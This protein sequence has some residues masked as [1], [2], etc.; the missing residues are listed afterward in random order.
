MQI[1]VVSYVPTGVKGV[2]AL[3]DNKGIPKGYSVL[4]LGAPGSGKTTF[5]LQFLRNGGENGERGIYVSMDEQP[6]MLLANAQNLGLGIKELVDA[7]KI[8]IIDASPIRVLP[9]R[10]KLGVTE[11]GRREFALATLVTSISEA[12]EKTKASR[13]VIDP[14]STLTIHFA[15]DY[16]RRVAFLDLLAAVSKTHCTTIMLAEMA[17]Q[18]SERS[19]HF[20]EFIAHGVMLLTRTKTDSAFT[21]VF[22]VEK[23]RGIN[24]D[25]QTHPY[26]IAKGGIQVFA[27]EQVL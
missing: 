12:V 21:R 18:V 9:A 8:T 17:E 19:Y 3:L 14:V 23:M 16:D 6:E 22:S 5:G 15:E 7:G 26:T 11:A 4:V 13:I 1:A 27:E 25:P 20:E 24:H 2:D 10:M